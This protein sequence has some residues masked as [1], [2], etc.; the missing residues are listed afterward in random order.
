MGVAASSR[1]TPTTVVADLATVAGWSKVP[2]AML[3]ARRMNP[4]TV[5]ALVKAVLEGD[6]ER[7]RTLAQELLVDAA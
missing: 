6:N 7:A 5:F 3:E 1:R 2:K 4:A